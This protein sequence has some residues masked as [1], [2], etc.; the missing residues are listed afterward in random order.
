MTTKTPAQAATDALAARREK[1][2]ANGPEKAQPKAVLGKAAHEHVPSMTDLMR[3]TFVRVGGREAM[4]RWAA[5]NPGDFY[6]MMGRML[7]TQIGGA[8]GGDFTVVLKTPEPLLKAI[9]GVL[10]TP[11]AKARSDGTA[12]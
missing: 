7:P 8:D 12:D 9:P 5:T 10:N 2:A 4:A 11:L 6:K 1:D 3:D